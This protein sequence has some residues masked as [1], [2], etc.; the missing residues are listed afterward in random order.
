MPTQVFGAPSPRAIPA[1]HHAALPP[2]PFTQPD[3]TSPRLPLPT[4]GQ[5]DCAHLC[6]VCTVTAL[7]L[8]S[9]PGPGPVSGSLAQAGNLLWTIPRGPPSA[10]TGPGFF[11][12]VVHT[13]PPRQPE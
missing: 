6:F 1:S 8:A 5:E 2:H 3:A 11:L 10:Y 4:P 12:A 9:V 7:T 13:S